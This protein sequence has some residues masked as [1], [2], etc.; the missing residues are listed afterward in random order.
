MNDITIRR[1]AFR[2]SFPLLCLLLAFGCYPKPK[3]PIDILR[4]NSPG[5]DHKQLFVFLPGNGDSLDTFE[6]NGLIQ[7]VREH[8]LSIDM[9]A[10]NA[11]LGYYMNGTI[12]TR[13]KQDVIDPAKARGYKKIWLIGNSLGGYGSIS[14]ARRYPQDISGVVLLGPFLGEK[15]TVREIVDAGGLQK[16]NPGDI[17]ENTK[18]GWEKELWK[19]LKDAEQQKCFW[20]WIKNCDEEHNDCPSRIYLGYGTGDRFSYGQKLMAGN[21]PP[22][23]V[24]AIDGGHNWRTWKKLWN[25][26]LDKMC[27]RKTDIRAEVSPN[28]EYSGHR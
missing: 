2:F 20:N 11:H 23:N 12:F 27:S 3:A 5:G 10:V 25:I 28:E 8:K 7:A 15:K 14:Y 17:P 19:W 26:I 22:E 9:I 16:W 4:Y 6:K 24:F 18:E 1:M 21:L 13:L